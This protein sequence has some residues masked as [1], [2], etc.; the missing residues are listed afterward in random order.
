MNYEK[1]GDE[2]MKRKI[3]KTVPLVFKQ[4]NDDMIKLYPPANNTQQQQQH[5]QYL[6]IM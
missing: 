6:K 3:N 4:L 5:K 1:S 2:T